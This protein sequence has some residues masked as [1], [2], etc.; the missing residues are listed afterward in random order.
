ML[1]AISVRVGASPRSNSVYPIFVAAGQRWA[2]GDSVYLEETPGLDQFR[3]S[4]LVAAWF[5]AWSGWPEPAGAI[6]WRWLNAA[7]LFGGLACWLRWQERSAELG[8][9][10]I[11]IAPLAIGGLNNGQCNAAIA[12]LLLIAQVCFAREQWWP[13]AGA[14]AMAALIKQ[15]PI[16]L[17]LLLAILEPRRFAPRLAVT[18]AIGLAAPFLLSDPRYV[19]DQYVAWWGRVLGDDRTAY[20]LANS[21]RDLQMLL[22]VWGWPLS[23]SG[24]R[25]LE[26]ALAVAA[27]AGV[28][29]AARRGHRRHVVWSCGALSMCWMTVAGPAT[30]SSTYVLAAPLLAACVLDR[31]SESRVVRVASSI[32]WMLLTVGATAVWWPRPIA[33]AITATG[34]QPLAGALLSLAVV[35]LVIRGSKSAT[36]ERSG[37]RAAA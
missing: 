37:L 10:L 32:S 31:G 6:V 17:G 1:L 9:A 19:A 23:L 29:F 22:R 8:A 26:L 4:P 12:G 21:Y 16:A 36:R 18:V 30:E 3:Y 7:V 20:P 11:L 35:A 13:A 28:V 34:I 14:V 24:Y 27:A 5:G 15:Y 25:L 2:A 33:Q